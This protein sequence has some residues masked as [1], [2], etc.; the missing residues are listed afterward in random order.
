MVILIPVATTALLAACLL[1]PVAPAALLAACLL[2][3][4]AP[5]A[6]LAAC[7]LIP[8]AP[9]ALLASFLAEIGGADP[10]VSSDLCRTPF[11]ENCPAHEHR[12]PLGEGEY[13]VH[14]VLDE[15]D[16]HL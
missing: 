6:L 11:D 4:V 7:L 1:I 13:E 14:V 9:A 3:P 16:G 15:K 10:L 5:T 12:D 8:V 2:I